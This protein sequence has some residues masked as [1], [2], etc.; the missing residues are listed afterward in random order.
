MVYDSTIIVVLVKEFYNFT[1]DIIEFLYKNWNIDHGIYKWDILNRNDHIE[2]T[3]YMSVILDEIEIERLKGVLIKLG[4]VAIDQHKISL[5]YYEIKKS[6]EHLNDFISSYDESTDDADE[7]DGKI[8]IQKDYNH[9]KNSIKS[10]NKQINS[11]SNSIR[12]PL[13]SMNKQINVDPN[14]IRSPLNSMNKQIDIDPNRIRSPLNSMNKQIN[15]DSNRIKS[16]S[17]SINKQLNTDLNRIKSP[18]IS[19]NKQSNTDLN[20]IKSPSISIN[21]QSTTDLNRIK[22]PSILIKKDGNSPNK[23]TDKFTKVNKSSLTPILN[24]K[25][26]IRSNHIITS[27]KKQ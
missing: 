17:I 5:N 23:S 18:S 2:L 21:K 3:I 9:S 7:Y 22:S 12:S 25:S 14:R 1:S 11:D 8:V 13:I 26:P 24:H 20:R 16:P 10:M 4:D 15:S 6:N 27:N 19:I